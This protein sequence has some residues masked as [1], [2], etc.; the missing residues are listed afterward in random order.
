MIRAAVKA[1]GERLDNLRG[2]PMYDAELQRD[3]AREC[4]L[5][6]DSILAVWKVWRKERKER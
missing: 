1:Y 6:V 2:D 5:E 3:M 4:I